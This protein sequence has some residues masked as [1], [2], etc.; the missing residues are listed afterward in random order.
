MRRN[1][2]DWLRDL[3]A[4]LASFIFHVVAMILLGLLTLHD[5]NEATLGDVLLA[6]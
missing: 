6:A 1:A 3:P 5:A 4:W 2:Y